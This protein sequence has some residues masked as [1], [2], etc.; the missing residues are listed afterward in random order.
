MYMKSWNKPQCIEM[1][2]V[3]E[4]KTLTLESSLYASGCHMGMHKN[5]E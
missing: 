4:Y 5:E 2:N 1:K 3:Q